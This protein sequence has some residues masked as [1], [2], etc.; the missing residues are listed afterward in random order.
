[1]DPQGSNLMPLKQRQH[2]KTLSMQNTTNKQYDEKYEHEKLYIHVHEWIML[3][4]L[5]Y[6]MSNDQIIEIKLGMWN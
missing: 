6:D 2:Q 1:M 3:D 5:S 4:D